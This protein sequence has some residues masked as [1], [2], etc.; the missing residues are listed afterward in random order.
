MKNDF[1]HYCFFPP[2]PIVH[3][4][5][6]T[7]KS[8]VDLEIF[9]LLFFFLLLF[10]S[11]RFR[12][13]VGYSKFISNGASTFEVNMKNARFNFW[14]GEVWKVCKSEWSNISLEKEEDRSLNRLVIIFFYE[15]RNDRYEPFRLENSMDRTNEWYIYMYIVWPSFI[16]DKV[17]SIMKRQLSKISLNIVNANDDTPGTVSRSAIWKLFATVRGWFVAWSC[18]RTSQ[19]D[20]SYFHD[21]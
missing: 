7:D 9:R 10:L 3:L 6:V 17:L 11:S 15:W 21:K 2:S 19:T 18:R 12:T 5:N 20:E 4:F 16:I 1:I 13:E 14:M 8:I